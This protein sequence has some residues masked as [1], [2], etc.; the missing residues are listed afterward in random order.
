M[1]KAAQPTHA[2]SLFS[3][4]SRVFYLT[5]TLF[6]QQD[7]TNMIYCCD[8]SPELSEGH[9]QN[10]LSLLWIQRPQKIWQDLYTY[11]TQAGCSA[12]TSRQI[13]SSSYPLLGGSCSTQQ[14]RERST[15]QDNCTL[16][17][18]TWLVSFPSTVL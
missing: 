7:L 3:A 11:H 1:F 12:G 4:S 17:Y 8:S 5:L 9:L 15:K 13:T 18:F 16:H 14:D 2:F 10:I 6:H